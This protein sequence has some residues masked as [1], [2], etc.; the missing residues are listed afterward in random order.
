VE[1]KRLG[2]VIEAN[3]VAKLVASNAISLPT[4]DKN[5]KGL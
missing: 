4:L 5:K 1:Y 3:N 2:R